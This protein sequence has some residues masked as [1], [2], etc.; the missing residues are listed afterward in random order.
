MPFVFAEDFRMLEA[1]LVRQ[2]AIVAEDGVHIGQTSIL[3]THP[4]FTSGER[5]KG[6]LELTERR[7]F[8][9]DVLGRREHP[10]VLRITI[11]AEHSDEELSELTLVTAEYRFGHLKGV[12]G[13][14]GPTRM[15]YEKVISVVQY[16]SSLVDE[17]FGT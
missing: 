4:E 5:L 3:A 12:I 11:G 7:D 16:T 9:A 1:D 2:C 17:M 14:I 10:P 6:I 8:L 15:P 13:V